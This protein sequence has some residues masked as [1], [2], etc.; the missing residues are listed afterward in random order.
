MTNVE[1][2]S[3]VRVD[4]DDIG[5]DRLLSHLQAEGTNGFSMADKIVLIGDQIAL[6]T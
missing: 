5:Y 4:Y 3:F 2:S 6:I 1:S